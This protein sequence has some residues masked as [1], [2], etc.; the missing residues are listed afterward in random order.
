MPGYNEVVAWVEAL[1]AVAK[2][3]ADRGVNHGGGIVGALEQVAAFFVGMHEG[4][5][6]GAI[7][8]LDN[9]TCGWVPGLNRAA[10]QVRTANAGSMAYTV[11]DWSA[12]V[13]TTTLPVGAVLK[14]AGIGAKALKIAN[15]ADTV[16]D[17]GR[18]GAKLLNGPITITESGL[19]HVMTRHTVN[20]IARWSGRSKFFAGEDIVGLITKG[21]QQPM[22][23]QANG[24]F[25]RVWD[26]GRQIGVDRA[27]GQPTSIMTVITRPN[28]ELVT[29]F[30][31]RPTVW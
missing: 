12:W 20:G 14:L 1:S 29:A 19:A 6:D 25:A 26:V 8:I 5:V 24:N 23:R 11:A 7:L 10:N 18:A 9:F 16:S 28:G 31:G 2:S 13:G 30:P 4:Q 22:V 15:S 3:N 27:T 17:L 21:T